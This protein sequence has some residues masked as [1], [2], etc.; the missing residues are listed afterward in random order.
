MNRTRILSLR[1]DEMIKQNYDRIRAE[2]SEIEE[3][4]LQ[5]LCEDPVLCKLFPQ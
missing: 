2:A 4:E 5:R 1:M 3:K